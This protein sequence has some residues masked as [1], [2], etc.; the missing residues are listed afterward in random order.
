[1]KDYFHRSSC[2][3]VCKWAYEMNVEGVE[4]WNKQFFDQISLGDLAEDNWRKIG[5]VV[6]YPGAP[7][8]NFIKKNLILTFQVSLSLSQ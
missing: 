2:S 6:Q 7:V 3:L 5:S 8:G 1:M 4:A